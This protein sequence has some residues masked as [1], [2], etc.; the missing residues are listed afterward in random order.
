MTNQLL[1]F[2]AALR[3]ARTIRKTNSALCL[4]DLLAT[5]GCFTT[6]AKNQKTAIAILMYS[7]DMSGKLK[8]RT[9]KG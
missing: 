1:R 6:A 2:I 7:L 4:I 8:Y 9:K 5:A 3:T